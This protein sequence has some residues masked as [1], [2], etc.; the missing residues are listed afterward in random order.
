MRSGIHR[1]KVEGEGRGRTGGSEKGK[2]EKGIGFGRWRTDHKSIIEHAS[3]LF[4]SVPVLLVKPEELL[5]C[6]EI[7]PEAERARG[8]GNSFEAK[9]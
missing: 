5:V 2:N 3:N 1:C 7:F 8:H 6:S 4:F 9:D